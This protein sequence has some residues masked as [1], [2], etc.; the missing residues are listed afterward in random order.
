MINIRPVSDLR[1]KY[2]EIEEEVLTTGSPVLMPYF[3]AG[4]DFA[5]M[6]PCR[7]RM[8]PPTAEGIVRRS[9][10]PGCSSSCFSADQDRKAELTSI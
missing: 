3:F 10:D 5:V 2:P 7:V 6:I 9:T 4:I 8:S 1:N